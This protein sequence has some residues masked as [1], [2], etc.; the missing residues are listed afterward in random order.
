MGAEKKGM[1]WDSKGYSK[2]PMISWGNAQY[3]HPQT[4]R[5]ISHVLT[6]AQM[7]GVFLGSWRLYTTRNFRQRLRDAYAGW[8]LLRRVPLRLLRSLKAFVLAFAQ[9]FG[10]H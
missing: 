7:S 6:T 9:F 5:K 3:A 4:W 8:V 2:T 1:L 10:R